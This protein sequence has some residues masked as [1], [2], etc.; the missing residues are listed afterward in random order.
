M[1]LFPALKPILR[2]KACTLWSLETFWSLEALWPLKPVLP[3]KPVGPLDPF[4]PGHALRHLVQIRIALATVHLIGQLAALRVRLERAK[5]CRRRKV[6]GPV[7]GGRGIYVAPLINTV[8]TVRPVWSVGSLNRFA[9]AANIAI[10]GASDPVLTIT[11]ARLTHP[12]RD[13]FRVQMI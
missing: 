8:D 12:I 1:G 6:G 4:R 10:I 5:I 3:L 11:R 2:P 9:A 7:I 13:R